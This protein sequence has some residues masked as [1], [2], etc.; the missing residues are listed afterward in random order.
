[1][2]A[3]RVSGKA[4]V[5]GY[6]THT[7]DKT[8]EATPVPLAPAEADRVLLAVHNFIALPADTHTMYPSPAVETHNA[9]F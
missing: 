2:T 1:M 7:A 9:R 6:N 4:I 8:A 5:T 3:K